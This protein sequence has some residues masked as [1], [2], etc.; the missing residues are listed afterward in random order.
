MEDLNKKLEYFLDISKNLHN[1]YKSEQEIYTRVNNFQISYLDE[2]YKHYCEN[3]GPGNL[4][5]IAAID[6]IRKGIK[7][8]QNLIDGIIDKLL[9][10]DLEY[11]NNL[12]INLTVKDYIHSSINEFKKNQFSKLWNKPWTLF[13]PLFYSYEKSQQVKEELE[14]TI[15]KE[16]ISR[17]GLENYK[18]TIFDFRGSN[19]TG[20]NSLGIAF[21][22]NELKNHKHAY[23]IGLSFTDKIKAELYTGSEVKSIKVD[24]KFEVKNF[25][26][27]GDKLLNI[28]VEADNLNKELLKTNTMILQNIWLLK[29][30]DEKIHEFFS[31]NLIAINYDD[32]NLGDLNSY[33]SKTDIRNQIK[34]TSKTTNRI[35]LIYNFYKNIEI[36]DLV[37]L[38]SGNDVI[39]GLAEVSSDYEFSINSK[40][41]KHRRNVKWIKKIPA[42]QRFKDIKLTKKT[43]TNYTN[44]TNA[45]VILD[46]LLDKG[47]PIMSETKIKLPENAKNIIFYGPPGTGKTHFIQK[48]LIPKFQNQTK[49]DTEYNNDIDI[50]KFSI[51]QI[52]TASLIKNG[53]STVSDLLNDPLMVKRFENSLAKEPRR[54]LWAELGFHTVSDCENV[55]VTRRLEPAFFYK[56]PDS[57]WEIPENLIDIAKEEVTELLKFHDYPS[58]NISKHIVQE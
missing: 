28:K 6:S 45:K 26:E 35:N 12:I 1:L 13:F 38:A 16:L 25:E 40:N 33:P 4:V 44:N 49:S 42:G 41:Y 48:E 19:H 10:G 20:G 37:I 54:S 30:D 27:L 32:L 22:P 7:V 8:D 5:R 14:K 17:L 24:R 57:T 58:Q 2:Y 36:G 43:L 23:Q 51:W 53:R 34:A 52:I 11:F 3:I 46:F 15:V 55:N 50:N 39:L 47:N 29:T 31:D 21:Y 18:Y 56:Y 9:N